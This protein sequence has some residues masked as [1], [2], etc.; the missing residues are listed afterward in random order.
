LAAQTPAFTFECFCGYLTEADSNCDICTTSLQSRMFKGLLIYKDSIAYR[1]I[2]QP[3]TILQNYNALTFRELITGAEQIRIELSGTPFDSI[4]QFRDSVLCPCAGGGAQVFIAGPGI[5]ITGDTITAVDTSAV[6]EA[7]TVSDQADYE[8]MTN[9]TLFFVGAGI[10]SVNFDSVTNIVTFTTTAPDG[11]ETIVT[12]GT[13]ISVSGSGTVGDPYVVTNTGDLSST[14]EAWTIDA[15]GGDTEVISNQTVLFEGA[16]IASTSYSSVT[17]TL[18]ITA[19]EVDGSTTNE[20]QTY[21]H[22][23]TTSY[24]NTLSGGGG[25]FTI[26][27]GT[28][29]TISQ[30]TGTVTISGAFGGGGGGGIYGD[31]TPGSGSDILP[32]GGSVVEIPSGTSPLSFDL[33]TAAAQYWTALSV[34][35]PYSADDAISVYLRGISPADSFRI[36]NY[37]GGTI[38]EEHSGVMTIQGDQELT[39]SF[40]SVNFQNIPTRTVLP[41]LIGQTGGGWL[42]KLEGTTT[43]QVP[44]WDEPNGY[45][46][47][48]TPAAGGL[49]AANNGLY[50]SGGNTVRMGGPLIEATLIDNDGFEFRHYGGGFWSFSD[51]TGG[52]TPANAYAGFAGLENLPTT[53]TSPTKDA[54][55]EFH[56]RS[57]I[58]SNESNAFVIGGYPTNNDGTWFQARS[59]S[60]PSF[61]YPASWQPRGGQFS[62]GRL[63][64]LDA[65]ATIAGAAL[66]GS[67]VAGSV[68]HLEQTGGHGNVPLSFGAGTDVLDAEIMWRDA[69]DALRVTNRSNSNNTSSIRFAIGGQTNDLAALVKSSNG[70]SLAKFGVGVG[71]PANIHSTIQS[72]GGYA[73]RVLTTVGSFTLDESNYVV[74]YTASGSVTWTLPT[75]STCTGRTYVLCSRGTGTVNLSVS[76]SKGNGG[77]FNS[78]SAGQWATIWSDG[79]GWTGYKLTSE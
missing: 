43:G 65:L 18:T 53:N 27:S 9:D 19:T 15:T 59:R 66:S 5:V 70:T 3:Y 42:Q 26:Q 62:I 24:T 25:A 67:A 50:V 78:L 57:S 52:F 41:F 35:T 7:W 71:A 1:W 76:V 56:P 8:L 17:N 58:G 79:S 64:G 14:N 29:I 45:W 74:I 12:A 6:N 39:V 21:G 77:N 20:L 47:L 68:L 38:I 40:D 4:A 44:T 33:G 30:T 51:Y 23:G 32:L 48:G 16:G 34:T 61:E 13:G 60:D 10:T 46:E 49:T 37:D 2:E 28:G 73:G 11:S 36:Y 31:G 63:G 54:I 22:A 72:A 69:D 55:I 75:A